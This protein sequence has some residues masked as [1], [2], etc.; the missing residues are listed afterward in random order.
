MEVYYEQFRYCARSVFVWL[1]VMFWR[2]CIV[3]SDFYGRFRSKWYMIIHTNYM[4]V[5]YLCA[6][7]LIRRCLYKQEFDVVDFCAPAVCQLYVEYCAKSL[8]HFH[9]AMRGMFMDMVRTC[10]KLCF[11]SGERFDDMNFENNV[12]LLSLIVFVGEII[13]MV[14]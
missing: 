4:I 11:R 7:Y 10:D 6:N 3:R 9:D 1:I 13:I 8:G 14:E 12:L 2:S 5:A